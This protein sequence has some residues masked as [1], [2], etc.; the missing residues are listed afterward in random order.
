[1]AKVVKKILHPKSGESVYQNFV[2][3]G[4]AERRKKGEKGVIKGIVPSKP[5][6]GG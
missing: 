4:K 5:G 3:F 1:M 2:A 6:K